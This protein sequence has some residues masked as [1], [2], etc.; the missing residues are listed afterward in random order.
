M[1]HPGTI[2]TIIRSLWRVYASIGQSDGQRRPIV[3]ARTVTAITAALTGAAV[4]AAAS[5]AA[6]S[7][8]QPSPRRVTTPSASQ[9]GPILPSNGRVGPARLPHSWRARVQ[10][11][12]VGGTNAGQGSLPYMAF[13]LHRGVDANLDFGCSATVVSS[14]VVMTAAHCAVDP[15]T[16]APLAPSGFGVVTG[17]VNWTD[18][19]H[20]RVSSVSRVIVDPAYN[21]STHVA[22]AALLVLSSY[23]TAPAV[24]LATSAD[25][26][27]ELAGTGALIAGWGG[28]DNAHPV[29]VL[30][31]APTVVQSGGYCGQYFPPAEDQ[32][33]ELCARNYPYDDTAACSADAGGPLLA[34]DSSGRPVEIG[35]S[36]AG[37]GNCGTNLADYFTTVWPLSSWASSWIRAFAP[38]RLVTRL[39]FVRADRAHHRSYFYVSAKDATNGR[40]VT[41]GLRCTVEQLKNGRWAVIGTIRQPFNFYISW[42]RPARGKA[43]SIRAVVFG[44]G[45]QNSTTRTLFAVGVAADLGRRQPNGL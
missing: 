12:I 10:P 24:R 38:R 7:P 35:I 39:V 2:G 44:S 3:P 6:A 5:G 23:T 41:R 20:R 32:S 13:I 31:W 33:V 14:N 28:A 16:G 18:T 25:Q 27:L 4:V 9:Q 45:Y 22:D 43:T 11:E 36:S 1:K 15:S 29:T 42:G 34:A 19:T 21:P 37:F 26:N 17:A 40:P 30:Q 8:G